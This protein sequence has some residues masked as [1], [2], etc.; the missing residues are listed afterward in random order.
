MKLQKLAYYAHGWNLGLTGE[1][2]LD[3]QIQAWSY[4]PVVFS[5]YKAFQE[6]GADE[7]MGRGSDWE[8]SDVRQ[9]QLKTPSLRDYPIR[10]AV[11]VRNLLARI[12]DVYR[13]TQQG[14]CPG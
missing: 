6:Y 4:G 9:P 5:V 10:E 12:W 2:L 1:P 14:N 3:E 7:I 11:Y 13:R 8:F